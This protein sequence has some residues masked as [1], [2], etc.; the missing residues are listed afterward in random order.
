MTGTPV[1]G[2]LDPAQI[3][4]VGGTSTLSPGQTMWT[5]FDLP[6]GTYGV[7]CFFPDIESGVEHALL[8][9]VVVFTVQ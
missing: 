8:G 1:A 2:G 5:A 7:A 3:T 6:P 9:M 4:N